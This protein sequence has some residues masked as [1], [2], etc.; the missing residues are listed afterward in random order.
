M[1]NDKS[2]LRNKNQRII[3]KVQRGRRSSAEKAV[4]SPAALSPKF[5]DED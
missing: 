2:L 5:V 3:P 1:I 4:Q